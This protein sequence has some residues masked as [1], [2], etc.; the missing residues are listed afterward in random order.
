MIKGF[1]YLS[2]SFMILVSAYFRS[3]MYR[4]Q[5]NKP[6][7]YLP[8]GDSYTIG[9]GA[10]EKEAWPFLL[11]QHLNSNKIFC[12]LATNPAR[13]GYSTQDLITHEL[14]LVKALNPDFV[15]L[16]IGVNDWVRGVSKTTF[17]KNLV[18]ILDELEKEMS[19][20]KN[21]ILLTIPDFGVTPA[22][23]KFSCGR[24]ISKGISDFNSVIKKEA[25][26]RKLVV[27]DVFEMSKN[28]GMDVTLVAEDSLH[29]SAE[30]YA[31]WEK[32]ILKETLKLLK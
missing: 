21:I 7:L 27:V 14:P 16:L 13:N 24:D 31:L 30:E 29:P 23:K 4:K 15:T 28:M 12:K 8:L 17:S 32:V 9:T 3:D 26:E 19:E 1:L 6:L 20:P 11:T 22:G 2:V 25:W 5:N 18:Y 10:L